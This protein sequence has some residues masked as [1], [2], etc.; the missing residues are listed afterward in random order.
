MIVFKATA[1]DHLAR[2]GQPKK[3]IELESYR[4]DGG[5]FTIY[6]HVPEDDIGVEIE[7]SA[8]DT[9]ELVKFLSAPR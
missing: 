6:V 8:E 2:E 9:A 7:L 3:T 5:F 4:V 1:P